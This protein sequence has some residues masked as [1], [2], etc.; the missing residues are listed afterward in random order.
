MITP[1]TDERLQEIEA[2]DARRLDTIFPGMT[3]KGQVRVL[4]DSAKNVPD[5]IA[6]LRR[7]KNKYEG[8]APRCNAGHDNTL[9]LALW[10]CPTCTEAVRRNLQAG[11]DLLLERARQADELLARTR[12]LEWAVH[13]LI[14]HHGES[15][16]CANCKAANALLTKTPAEALAIEKARREVVEAAR[17]WYA[18]EGRTGTKASDALCRA[19]EKLEAGS[20]ATLAHECR[21][22]HMLKH[23]C[24]RHCCC[25]G[26]KLEDKR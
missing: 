14:G 17:E 3:D 19:L 2:A 21:C 15:G 4:W 8:D 26:K 13:L 23:C 11:Q 10:D 9:P 16:S 24:D 5:L 12:E 6:E 7:L 18:A 22:G 20:C 25:H 1:M